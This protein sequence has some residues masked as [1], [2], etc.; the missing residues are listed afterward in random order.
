MG[1]R[2]GLK[3]KRIKYIWFSE[4][5]G[6]IFCSLFRLRRS[7]Y[8]YKVQNI[9]ESFATNPSD[10]IK[11]RIN[12][13]SA[14]SDK[15]VNVARKYE[16]KVGDDD[17]FIYMEEMSRIPIFVK[18]R[19]A[20]ILFTISDRFYHSIGFLFGI[21]MASLVKEFYTEFRDVLVWNVIFSW[22]KKVYKYRIADSFVPFFADLLMRV[23]SRFACGFGTTIFCQ[24]CSG[25]RFCSSYYETEPEDFYHDNIEKIKSIF[26]NIQD[27]SRWRQKVHKLLK[28]GARRYKK[29]N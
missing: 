28:V 10:Y 2:L 9:I 29:R 20:Y 15:V 18:D 3:P 5:I 14:L 16:F 4:F 6:K 7:T 24:Y 26:A 1:K 22:K 17:V 23:F 27:T 13:F 8:L 19:E 12:H 21:V 11:S 25:R